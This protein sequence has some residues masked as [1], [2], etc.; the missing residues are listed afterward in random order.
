MQNAPKLGTA[1]KWGG[2]LSVIS[3][4]SVNL[5]LIGRPQKRPTDNEDASVGP[6]ESEA[7]LS[8]WTQNNN[9]ISSS[10]VVTDS[11]RRVSVKTNNN[12]A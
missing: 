11:D 10:F 3:D 5:G 4:R 12:F 2:G 1:E 6:S 7:E 9:V 8:H